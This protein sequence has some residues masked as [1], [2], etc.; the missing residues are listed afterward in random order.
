VILQDKM[1]QRG[2]TESETGNRN[3]GE[4][5]TTWTQVVWVCPGTGHDNFL[6]VPLHCQVQWQ[7]AMTFL[8]QFLRNWTNIPSRV[9]CMFCVNS[10]P[11]SRGSQR[12]QTPVHHPLRPVAEEVVS[13]PVWYWVWPVRVGRHGRR[14]EQCAWNL[15]GGV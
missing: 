7:E 8:R 14:G 11:W 9:T 15:E 6:G 5:N 10:Q 12:S 4:S 1:K 2:E 3:G 13:G